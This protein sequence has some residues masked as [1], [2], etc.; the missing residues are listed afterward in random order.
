MVSVVLFSLET[1]NIAA[2]KKG[3]KWG[4]DCLNTGFKVQPS[5]C[6][7][8]KHGFL[9][10]VNVYHEN[11]PVYPGHVAKHSSAMEHM[12]YVWS[13]TRGFGEQHHMSRNPEPPRFC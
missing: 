11:N 10:H 1:Q 2:K 4:K 6:T 9:T 5:F 13:K 7:N 8:K 3:L 12:T